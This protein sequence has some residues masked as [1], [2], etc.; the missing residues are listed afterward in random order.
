MASIKLGAIITD[1]AGSIGGTT[2]RRTPRGIIAYN[3]QGTQIKSAFAPNSVKAQLGD[4]FGRWASLSEGDKTFW[5]EQATIYQFPNKFG[6][7]VNLTGR[8][9]FTKLNAQLIPTQTTVGADN[10]NSF[11]EPGYVYLLYLEWVAEQMNLNFTY[12]MPASY[13]LVSIYPLRNG[14]EAKPHLKTKPKLV[15]FGN[16]TGQVSIF[17][18]FVSSFPYYKAGEK[19]GINVQTMNESGFMSSVQTFT[20][21]V[22]VNQNV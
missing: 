4:I 13:T 14:E 22:G 16:I 1:I 3:K 19:Y 17:D 21:I 5:N 9:F 7:L 18:T 10:F 15:Q 20:F 12:N 11:M 6:Q 8:Q 2:F